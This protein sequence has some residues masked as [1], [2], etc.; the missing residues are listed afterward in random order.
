QMLIKRHD[1]LRAIILPSGQQQV[2]AEVSAYSIISYDFTQ[3]DEATI[4]RHLE[5]VRREMFTR[6][7]SPEQWPLFDIR[8][9]QLPAQELRI[10]FSLDM[11]IADWGSYEILLREWAQLYHQPSPSLPALTLSFRDYVLAERKIRET[12]R[13]QRAATYWQER[14]SRL[15]AAPEL[16]LAVVPS[17]LKSAKFKRHRAFL[18]P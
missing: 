15:P 11:L 14:L 10:H 1:M 13:Y 3:A 8:F 6:S 17:T 5:T 7:F 12:D 9:S 2:L 16:P 4:N 18:E